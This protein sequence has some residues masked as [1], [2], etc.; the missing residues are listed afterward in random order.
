MMISASLQLIHSTRSVLLNKG[1]ILTVD[2]SETEAQ[3]LAVLKC[4]Y[5]FSVF[6]ETVQCILAVDNIV[7]YLFLLRPLSILH[8]R[9]H[10]MCMYSFTLIMTLSSCFFFRH[11]ETSHKVYFFNVN[12]QKR[13]FSIIFLSDVFNTQTLLRS[14]FLLRVDGSCHLQFLFCFSVTYLHIIIPIIVMW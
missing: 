8:N 1:S 11:N 5:F 14:L 9:C 3:A 6:L 12:E 7:K 2:D 13:L 4:L 10:S